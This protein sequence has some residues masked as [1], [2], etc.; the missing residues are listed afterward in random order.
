MLKQQ[1]SLLTA[2]V[3]DSIMG[4]LQLTN[5]TTYNYPQMLHQQLAKSAYYHSIQPLDTPEAIIDEIKTRCKDAEPYAPGSHTAP[6]T[7]FCCLYR[8]FVMRINSKVLG[9]LI[10]YHGA[11]YVRCAGFL[12]VRFGLSPRDYWSFL[13]PH[14]L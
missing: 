11:P 14:L 2:N 3:N 8:L 9:Q 10:N 5:T 6:S 12:Y 4:T 7:M 1:Q 13:Q